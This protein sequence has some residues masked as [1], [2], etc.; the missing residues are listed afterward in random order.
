VADLELDLFALQVEAHDGRVALRVDQRLV[1]AE[2]QRASGEERV[3]ALVYREVLQEVLRPLLSLEVRPFDVH[4][5]VRKVFGLGLA[6]Y[7]V[8]R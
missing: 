8:S 3:D 6:V 1:R 2:V 7:L 5:V 4:L